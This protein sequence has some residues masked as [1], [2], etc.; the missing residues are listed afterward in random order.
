MC[1][2]HKDEIFLTIY[3]FV[4][5]IDEKSMCRKFQKFSYFARLRY[6]GVQLQNSRS[7]D[8]RLLKI[9]YCEM[10]GL[11]R[12]TESRFTFNLFRDFLSINLL[13]D[14]HKTSKL[15]KYDTNAVLSYFGLNFL[16][17]ILKLL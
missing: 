12:P 8:P 13:L 17:Y 4:D 6:M 7:E 3:L 15:L 14:F 2:F 1:V 10:S 9:L 11:Q 5:F 16:R